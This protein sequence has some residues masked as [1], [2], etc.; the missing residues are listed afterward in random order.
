M[1]FHTHTQFL[2]RSPD[3]NQPATKEE[4]KDI[5][6]DI[7]QVLAKAGTPFEQ[8]IEP[9]Q[10]EENIYN[11]PPLH[12]SLMALDYEYNFIEAAFLIGWFSE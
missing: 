5:Q 8:R 10:L 4:A 9:H 2:Q 6:L 7:I 3:P 1:C 12:P 11:Q